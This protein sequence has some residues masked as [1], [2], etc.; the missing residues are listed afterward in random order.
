MEEAIRYLE[1]SLRLDNNFAPAHAQLAIATMILTGIVASPPEE[2]RRTAIRHLDRAQALEPDLA[3]AHAGRALL[4]RY[5]NDPE[6]TVEHAR[7]ALA[8]NPNYIDAMHWL[9][10]ALETLGRGEEAEAIEKQMLVTDPMSVIGRVHYAGGL[11]YRGRIEEAHELADQ[12]LAQSQYAG[13]SVHAQTSLWYEGKIAESLSWALRAPEGNIYVI[14]AF[15]LV[16]EFDE[17]RRV[18]HRF[19]YWADVVQGRWDE[20]IQATQRN[21]QLNPDGRGAIADAAEVLYHAGR[22]DEALP[23][24]ERLLEFVPEGQPVPG[25]GSLAMTMRLALARRKAGDEEGAQAAAEIARQDH[26]AGRADGAR[27]QFQDLAEAMIAAFEHDPDRAI[28]ALK[29]AIQRGLRI[30]NYIIDPIFEDLRDEPRFV[31]LQEELD[32][33]LAAE[34]DRV[35][36]LICFNNPVPEDWQPMLETCEGVMEQSSL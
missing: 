3:E 25:W 17:A 32:T 23:L 9:R 33:M 31:A 18:K 36:Q 29:S 28:A 27:N 35:L 8:S 13:Y 10:I 26:A 19:T 11:I 16:G 5:A 6:S 2:A 30:P 4:A 12:L 7:K 1:R 22:I 34:H 15:E 14:Y 24:Y 20:A 21:L